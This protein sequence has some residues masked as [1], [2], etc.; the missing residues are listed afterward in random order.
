MKSNEPQTVFRALI[1]ITAACYLLL[2]LSR[3]FL[4]PIASGHTYLA[5]TSNGDNAAIKLPQ[6][7]FWLF[8][9]LWMA[10]A[11][12]IY[13]FH[14][15]ARLVLAGLVVFGLVV[16]LLGGLMVQTAFEAFAGTAGTLAAGGA[17][18]LAYY[19]PLKER[20]QR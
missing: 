19:S 10:T 12:G 7:I 4:W 16:S 14:S 15:R 2:L 9:L 1:V 13:R 3:W 5:L 17:L 20:F 18:A 11:I 8:A 6:W